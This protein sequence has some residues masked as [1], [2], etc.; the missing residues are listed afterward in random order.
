VAGVDENAIWTS[1]IDDVSI[2]RKIAALIHR[3]NDPMTRAMLKSSIIDPHIYFQA[4]LS[5]VFS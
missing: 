4:R 2:D 3:L 5:T 1:T